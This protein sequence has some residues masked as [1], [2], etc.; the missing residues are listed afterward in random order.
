MACWSVLGTAKSWDQGCFNLLQGINDQDLSCI[1]QA[2]YFNESKNKYKS[3][4][5][6]SPIKDSCLYLIIAYR[7]KH[8]IITILSSGCKE[9][10]VFFLNKQI[11]SDLI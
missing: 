10:R 9:E 11:F 7:W 2:V 1:I 8:F 5:I 3:G 4:S 6:N